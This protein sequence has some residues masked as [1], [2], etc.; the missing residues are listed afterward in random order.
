MVAL[1]LLYPMTRYSS[2]DEELEGSMAISTITIVGLSHD[3]AQKKSYVNFVWADD[4]SKRLGLEVPYG[5][6]LDEIEEA[7]G[8]AV[9]DFAREMTECRIRM[10]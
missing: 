3:L 7:A 2:S 5:T 4:P 1:P 9:A 10:P 8:K 6:S